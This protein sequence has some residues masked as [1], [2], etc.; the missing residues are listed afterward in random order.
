[1]DKGTKNALLYTAGLAAVYLGYRQY[2]K[3][4][5]EIQQ[6]ETPATKTPTASPVFEDR[7][8]QYTAKVITLQKLLGVNT[9]GVIGTNTQKAAL[10]FGITY[11]IDASNIDKTIALINTF[12]ANAKKVSQ[13]V[14]SY[15]QAS[16][17]ASAINAGGT[18]RILQDINAQAFVKAKTGGFTSIGEYSRFSKGSI[19]GKGWAAGARPNSG[20]L[21][22]TK[23]GR[24][25]YQIPANYLVVI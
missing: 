18:V 4:Q 3:K 14:A 12:N 6:E 22:I 8:K 1:M 11:K 15:S 16:K 5:G 17:M 24:T 25:Y 9:D 7:A 23:N 20:N 10:K 13:S 2:K 19:L 21:L